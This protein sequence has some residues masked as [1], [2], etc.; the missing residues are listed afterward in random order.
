MDQTRTRWL[1]RQVWRRQR[2]GICR[3]FAKS[4]AVDDTTM[5]GNDARLLI[6][7]HDGPRVR[8]WHPVGGNWFYEIYASAVDRLGSDRVGYVDIPLG[9]GPE[10]WIALVLEEIR[11][12]GATH[13]IFQM[14]RDPDKSDA[15]NWD[16]LV[17]LLRRSGNVTPIAVHY[18]L[19]FG[20][21]QEK[22]RRL[23]RLHPGLMSVGL[24]DPPMAEIA[25]DPQ[26][27]GPVTMPV[28]LA[29]I[30]G[31]TEI[32]QAAERRDSISF[33]GALYDDR[34]PLINDLKRQRPNLLVNPH[35]ETESVD[36]LGSRTNQ[37]N[38]ENY[39]RGLASTEFTINF[40]RSSSGEA[41]QYKT[42]VI[43]TA[44]LGT[45]L[46]TDDI[47]WTPKL[48]PDD[49]VLCVDSFSDISGAL[50]SFR[51]LGPVKERR[52]RL[53]ALGER[54]ATDHFWHEVDRALLNVHGR[55]Q[56]LAG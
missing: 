56:S 28:S 19:H 23:H 54:L 41:L 55:G 7:P 16:A 22:L 9:V 29:T 26:S 46:I 3:D 42:R 6:V 39:L 1:D 2:R 18:D 32:R 43:E 27:V 53:I 10:L 15:W 12:Q 21:I 4:L 5:V 37:P 35:H 17:T 51:N 34:V 40:A 8:G 20:W 44:L 33:L 13:V 45:F 38:Y 50:D 49:L 11:A 48:F 36:Y 25:K 24:A 52:E 47:E 31:F 30:A 14:E